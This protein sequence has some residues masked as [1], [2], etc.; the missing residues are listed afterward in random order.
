MVEK[1]M[2]HLLESFDLRFN[3]KKIE[4]EKILFYKNRKAT[5]SV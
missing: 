1:I 5:S 3:A 4:I 2:K